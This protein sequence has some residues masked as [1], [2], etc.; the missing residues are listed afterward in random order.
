MKEIKKL[1]KI[2]E[3]EFGIRNGKFGLFIDFS[4]LNSGVSHEDWIWDYIQVKRPEHAK[5]SE[6]ERYE[7]T[8]DLIKRISKY[9]SQAKVENIYELKDVPVELT[10]NHNNYLLSWRILTEVL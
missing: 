8:V 6:E 10:F 1:G 9:L 4:M 5:W 2:S 7:N 3:V